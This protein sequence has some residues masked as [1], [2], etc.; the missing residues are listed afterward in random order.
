MKHIKITKTSKVNIFGVKV[1]QLELKIDC[2]WGKKG[3]KGG[4]VESK[5]NI[6]TEFTGWVSGDAWVSGNAR[7]SGDAWVSGNA[8]V[9]GDAW[10]Y[11][12]ARVYWDARV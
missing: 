1:F 4:W 11:G 9:Y 3:E 10:V 12:D 7:V 8:R 6:D 2:K 5:E